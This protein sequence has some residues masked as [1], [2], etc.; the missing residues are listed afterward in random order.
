MILPFLFL[1]ACVPGNSPPR[2]LSFNGVEVQRSLFGGNAFIEVPLS[3]EPGAVLELELE[4]REPEGQDVEIWLPKAPPGMDWPY[5]GLQGTWTIPDDWDQP[6]TMLGIIVR[7]TAPQPASSVLYVG[8]VWW[9]G[10]E[11]ET[12]GPSKI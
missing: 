8:F 7:D 4:V 11:W 12:G 5:D 9:E 2:F 10:M 1:A 6:Y 3:M